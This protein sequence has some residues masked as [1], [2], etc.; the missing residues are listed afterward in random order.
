MIVLV[1]TSIW[2]VAL[3][4]TPRQLSP[5]QVTQLHKLDEII[6]EGRVRLLGPVR[7]EILSGI[8]FP[9]QFARLQKQLRTFPD[10]PLEI[11]DYEG[12]AQMSNACRTHGVIGSPIDFLLCS[13]AARRRWAIYTADRDFQLY[14]KHIPLTLFP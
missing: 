13:A 9:E 2:S 3:R 6:T 7:Q 11:D 8:R 12:A 10:V 1:D 4:R 14:A 5:S